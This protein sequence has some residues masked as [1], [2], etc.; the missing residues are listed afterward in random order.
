MNRVTGLVAANILAKEPVE[1]VDLGA[2]KF[3]N[4]PGPRGQFSAYLLRL[5][6]AGAKTEGLGRCISI[7]GTRRASLGSW[8]TPWEQ[9]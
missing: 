6:A 3:A 2:A 5:P 7:T 8:G 4:F 9:I 1:R